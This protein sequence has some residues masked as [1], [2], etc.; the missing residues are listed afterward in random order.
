MGATKQEIEKSCFGLDIACNSL[1]AALLGGDLWLEERSLSGSPLVARRAK[2]EWPATRSSKSEEWCGRR[3]SNSHASRRWYLKPVRLPIPPRPHTMLQNLSKQ[4][5][6]FDLSKKSTIFW[7][8]S[9]F[10]FWLSQNKNFHL[11]VKEGAV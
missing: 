2:P 6:F 3:D 11:V 8:S 4:I 1:G 9:Y 7:V 10:K 5:L